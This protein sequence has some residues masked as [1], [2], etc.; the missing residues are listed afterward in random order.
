ME[1]PK[2]PDNNGPPK[3]SDDENSTPGLPMILWTTPSVMQINNE[4]PKESSG[5][6]NKEKKANQRVL[7]I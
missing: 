1:S 5:D 6:N 2:S 7:V 4:L 3:E